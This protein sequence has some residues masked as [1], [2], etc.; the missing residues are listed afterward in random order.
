MR[1]NAKI[2]SNQPAIVEAL[3]GVGASV[4]HTHMIGQGFPD[5][6]VG[7]RGVNYLMEIK[8][9]SLA[10]SRRQLTEDE[11]DWHNAWH[12]AV[13]I[14]ESVEDAYK[15]IGAVDE[16]KARRWNVEAL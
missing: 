3:R 4:A 11:K 6:V 7:F 15:A 10:P 9:G 8:D 1:R 13:V 5:I 14:V 16:D 2:D 12:G